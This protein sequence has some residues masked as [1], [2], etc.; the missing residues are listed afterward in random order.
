MTRKETINE[1][2]KKEALVW[3]KCVCENKPWTATHPLDYRKDNEIEKYHA[4]LLSERK[5]VVI[6][7]KGESK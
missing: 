6:L 2:P 5:Q 1:P 3:V 4:E 7:N